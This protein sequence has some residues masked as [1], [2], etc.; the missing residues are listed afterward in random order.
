MTRLAAGSYTR[1]MPTLRNLDWL[2]YYYYQDS[3]KDG[4]RGF[5]FSR[6]GGWGDHRH[7]IHFSG[8]SDTGWKMLGFEV[9]FTSTAGNVGCFYWSHDV[10]GH[11][12]DRNEEPYTRW[13]QFAATNAALRI[14]SGII[15]YLDRRPWK[16]PEQLT[17]SMRKAFHFRSV[18][19][20]ISI[21]V[22][23]SVMK[24]ITFKPADVH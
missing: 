12:G 21:A 1:G 24:I 9:P 3:K 14:H 2:N 23:G 10:G 18:T 7:P 8:D 11:F 16:W 6:W 4:K 5:Q 17:D 19:C 22:F 13:V 20:L 15:D